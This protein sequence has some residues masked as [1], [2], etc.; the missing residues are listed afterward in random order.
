MLFKFRKRK[1]RHMLYII[2][3]LVSRTY[4]TYYT[5]GESKGNG[6]GSMPS[7]CRDNVNAI[8]VIL[9]KQ[10]AYN[11]TFCTTII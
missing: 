6:V 10:F 7:R 11:Y 1:T 9:F 2:I 3:I 4:Y 5:V 8:I